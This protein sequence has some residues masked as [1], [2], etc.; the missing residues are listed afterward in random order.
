M[1]IFVLEHMEHH[2]RSSLSE[3]CKPEWH[4]DTFFFFPGI[5]MTKTDPSTPQ[6]WVIMR[7]GT[8]F[9][10]KNSIEVS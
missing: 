4:C 9:H 2:S 7:S 1:G 10:K 3:E 5:N 8:N 6:F